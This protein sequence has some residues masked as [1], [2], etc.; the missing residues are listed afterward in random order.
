MMVMLG[1]SCRL[2]T[3]R[4]WLNWA[5]KRQNALDICVVI[6]ILVLC[7]NVFLHTMKFLGVAIVCNF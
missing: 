7:F 6:M 1:A 2:V 3:S 4:I 5:S